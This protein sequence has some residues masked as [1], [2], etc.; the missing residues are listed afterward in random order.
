M[1]L[2]IESS[3]A[4]RI[5]KKLNLMKGRLGNWVYLGSEGA[6]MDIA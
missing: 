5:Q 6:V 1:N 3:K 4:L 2:R